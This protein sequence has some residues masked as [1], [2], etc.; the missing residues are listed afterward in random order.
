MKLRFWGV[1]GVHPSAGE[2]FVRYGGNTCALAIDLPGTTTGKGLGL[3]LDFGTGA[4]GVGRDLLGAGFG[5]GQGKLAVLLTSAQLDH[6][7]ALPFFVPLFIPGNQIT[8]LGIGTDHQSP[9]QLL[10]DLLNPHY[11]PINSLSNFSANLDIRAVESGEVVLAGLGP[12]QHISALPLGRGPDTTL[13]WRVEAGGRSVALVG[14]AAWRPEAVQSA[15]LAWAHGVDV[16]VHNSAWIERLEPPESGICPKVQSV[17]DFAM[18]CGAGKLVLTHHSPYST[19]AH[20]DGLQQ[21]LDQKGGLPVVV[22]HE[23]LVLEL[24]A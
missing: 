2:A 19:D 21:R 11:S 10:E 3:L 24:G 4:I 12:D 13:A 8:V 23:G 22:A 20:L 16:L 7:G 6:T 17:M 9:R 14:D 1:R 5:A 18:A 15:V